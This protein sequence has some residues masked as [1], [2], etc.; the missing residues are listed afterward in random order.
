MSFRGC[1]IIESEDEWCILLANETRTLPRTS[2][3]EKVV[4]TVSELL[5]NS[6]NASTGCIIAPASN[7]CFFSLLH[8]ES[9]F[10]IRDRTTLIYELENHLPID[11]ESMSADFAML[12]QQ[13]KDDQSSPGKSVAA[14]AIEV[15]DWKPLADKLETAGFPVTNIIPS[16][17]LTVASLR[18][19]HSLSGF[20]NLIL[21]HGDHADLITL[22][23][24][25]ILSWKY[26]KLDAAS[27][28]RHKFLEI[29][30]SD[31]I[32]VVGG[33]ETQITLI[34][35]NAGTAKHETTALRTHQLH[36]ADAAISK[37]TS[38]HFNLRRDRLASNDPLRPISRQ[39]SWLGFAVATC[40]C[41]IIAGSWWRSTRIEAKITETL[42][43]Q[44]NAFKESFPGIRVPASL[45][46]RV[47][48]EHSRI[49]GSRNASK[50]I[51]A[52]ESATE[53]MGAI[54]ASLPTNIRLRINSI[55][56]RNGILDLAFQVQRTVDAGA[57]AEALSKAG[58]DVSPPVTT[59]KDGKTFDSTI[60]AQ[61]KERSPK[62]TGR[63]PETPSDPAENQ[64][65]QKA[66]H[67]PK[68]SNWHG[69]PDNSR[70]RNQAREF[71]SK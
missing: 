1:L 63:S 56:I 47:R 65:S 16:V 58:F 64:N 32:L 61:W 51:E 53:V 60:Q 30:D 46:R 25:Q 40:L 68:T 34:R 29:R 35:D 37:P 18:A 45:L 23:D 4:A 15:K 24:D 21:C 22:A 13:A 2:E 57:V 48:S 43:A 7:S 27:L 66:L 10:D 8:F 49:M 54:L 55:D 44:S 19:N 33:T 31:E 69:A 5:G 6:K 12:P 50:Q 39:L 41:V 28:K 3:V 17:E 11:A 52:P 38:I 59:Q 9:D 70:N 20:S 14:V 26:S 67:T 42:R 62:S 36:G 71:V